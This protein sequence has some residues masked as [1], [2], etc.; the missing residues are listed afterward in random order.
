MFDLCKVKVVKHCS[1]D[2]CISK[3]N[4]QITK[5]FIIKKE[6]ISN[7]N[8]YKVAAAVDTNL[9]GAINSQTLRVVKFKYIESG[10]VM[11][12]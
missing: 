11:L 7:K 3:G 6:E 10:I 2:K 4:I 9:Y 8:A 1:R 5:F 12:L